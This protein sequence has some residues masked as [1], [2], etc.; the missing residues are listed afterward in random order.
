MALSSTKKLNIFLYFAQ[1]DQDLYK[2][3][4]NHLTLLE[5]EYGFYT[6][7]NDDIQP[8]KD[9]KETLELLLDSADLVLFLISSDFTSNEDCYKHMQH[10]LRLQHANKANAVF[11]HLRPGFVPTDPFAHT[12]TFPP[13]DKPI[14]MWG[15]IDAAYFDVCKDI[16]RKIIDLR[17]SWDPK[18]KVAQEDYKP[19]A[20]KD[21][22]REID[23]SDQAIR[24]NPDDASAYLKK[25][26]ALEALGRYKEAIRMLD[27]A[28][29]LNPDEASAYLNKGRA[30]YAR[31]RFKKAITTIDKAI[32]LNPYNPVAF[33]F[34]GM[35]LYRLRYHKE[36]I[37]VLKEAINLDPYIYY[38]PVFKDKTIRK[39]GH[40]EEDV[41]L[42]KETLRLNPYNPAAVYSGR[43]SVFRNYAAS[44]SKYVAIILLVLISVGG[45]SYGFASFIYPKKALIPLIYIYITSLSPKSSTNTPP[46]KSTQKK[47]AQTPLP[48]PSSQARYFIQKYYDY[49]NKH[50][51]STAYLL[52][53]DN[54]TGHGKS[55]DEFV[56]GYGNTQHDDIII[57][58]VVPNKNNT[59][60][61]VSIII[62]AT[63]RGGKKGI[64]RA[65]YTV[66]VVAD[67]SWR[68]I[69]GNNV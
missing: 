22:E 16:R 66:G 36:A 53:Q 6:C 13:H 15:N 46:K 54:I 21:L 8:G 34:K 52:W 43:E 58:D 7:S 62:E 35:A 3:L 44:E 33:L 20:R 28:I 11:V 59:T 18:R 63:E 48:S 47:L 41:S 37:S 24:A 68:I 42:L 50:E 14:T 45:T 25:G 67:G 9:W 10:V 30:L 31:Q 23:D 38:T 55:Y 29:K 49:I 26:N 32:S 4:K 40:F 61:D 39:L 56:A 27:E 64:Y 19:Y 57:V 51:Y 69:K 17:K 5:R 1:E 60:F 2:G 65:Y 12:E